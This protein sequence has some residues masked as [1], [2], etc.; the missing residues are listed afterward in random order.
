MKSMSTSWVRLVLSAALLVVF[1]PAWSDAPSTADAATSPASADKKTGTSKKKEWRSTEVHPSVA[2]KDT[3]P[4]EVVLPGVLTIAGESADALDFTRARTIPLTNGGAVS[5][6]LSLKEPN[7]IQL[8]FNDPYVIANTDVEVKK[9]ANSN[10]IYIE[11]VAGVEK[12]VPIFIEM[13]DGSGPVLGLQ[14]IPKE[15]PAQ[16]IIVE[17]VA[18]ASS[19]SRAITAKSGEYV[20]SV[21]QLMEVAALGGTPNGFSIVELKTPPIGMNGLMVEVDKKLSNRDSDIYIYKVTNPGTTKTTVKENEF[22]G[23]LVQ[24]VSIFP[25]PLLAPGETIRVIV[26]ARKEKMKGGQ[27]V[28]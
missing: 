9:R 21:Q 25:S 8:P 23:D 17:D 12:A 13:P 2:V 27:Y 3:K 11:F 4:K 5:V 16:T 20:S 18:G 26:M 22:D 28:R 7:R 10:N 6:Y 24:A 1:A 19:A 14:L 15:I